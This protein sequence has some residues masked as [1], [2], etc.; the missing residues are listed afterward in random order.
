MRRS[1]LAD[2]GDKGFG[3]I[4]IRHLEPAATKSWRL[5]TRSRAGV[6]CATAGWR[7][8]KHVDPTEEFVLP[9]LA[10]I[11]VGGPPTEDRVI[12]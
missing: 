8:P 1:I 10:V 3:L 6:G 7:K 12:E 9:V 11:G 2:Y 4:G 5:K